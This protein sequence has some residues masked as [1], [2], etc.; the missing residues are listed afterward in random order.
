MFGDFY[1]HFEHYLDEMIFSFSVFIYCSLF[2]SSSSSGI[3]GCLPFHFCVR[4]VDCYL[5]EGEKFLYR[6]AMALAR[7]FEKT[8]KK[9][10]DIE[11]MRVFCQDI[12]TIIT[13]TE[14]I[15]QAIKITRFSRKGIF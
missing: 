2:S 7:L 4:I 14:L 1:V 15:Q 12:A 6:I 5:V 13:P 9:P 8:Q 11:Q 10:L 3:F